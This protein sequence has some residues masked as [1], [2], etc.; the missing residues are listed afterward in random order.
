[1][2]IVLFAFLSTK[3]TLFVFLRSF[4]RINTPPQGV[5]GGGGILLNKCDFSPRDLM[6]S[7]IIWKAMKCEN[8]FF[9]SMAKKCIKMEGK[10][11][12]NEKTSNTSSKYGNA[13]HI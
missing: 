6:K 5:V 4:R 11:T 9:P 7:G 12:N 13:G 10:S 3:T 1:M 8:I 2:P